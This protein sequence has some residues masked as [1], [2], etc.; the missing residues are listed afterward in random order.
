M[1]RA[2]HRLALA[3]LIAGAAVL[4]SACEPT[5]FELSFP[6]ELPITWYETEFEKG[7]PITVYMPDVDAPEEGFPVIIFT[8]GWNQPRASYVSYAQQLSQWGYVCIIRFYPSLGLLGLGNTYMA[9]H[10]DQSIRLFNWVEAENE[11]PDSPLFGRVDRFN[12][13]TTGHSMGASVSVGTAVADPRVRATVSLDVAYATTDFDPINDKPYPDTDNFLG[14][15][16]SAILYIG[17]TG[18]GWC[19]KPPGS[20][21]LMFDFTPAPTGEILIDGASHMDF[22]DSLNGLGTF[23]NIF[24]MT[25]PGPPTAQDVRDITMRYLIPWFNVHLKGLTEFEEYYAGE[26]AIEDAVNG[27]TVSRL[28]LDG[29]VVILG[30]D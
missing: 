13:G 18:N 4:F 22:I 8:P 5:D 29:E 10:I 26:A 30:E 16:V 2:T 28:N 3:A 24:C 9:E 20:S 21:I 15:T 1:H 19:A 11:N 23:G 7:L 6:G 27:T 12:F 14:D 25:D 17:A